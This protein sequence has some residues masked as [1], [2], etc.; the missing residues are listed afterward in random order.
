MARAKT[1]KAAAK[2]GRKQTTKRVSAE[3]QGGAER[4]AQDAKEG[5]DPRQAGRPEGRRSERGD[6]RVAK[7]IVDVSLGHDDEAILALYAPDIESS[8]AGQ[9]P[10]VGSTRSAASSPAG[11]T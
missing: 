7:R 3:A 6:A 1:K 8:E 2:A 9:P 4:E 11:A 5:S 10:A